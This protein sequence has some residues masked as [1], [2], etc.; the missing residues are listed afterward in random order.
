MSSPVIEEGLPSRNRDQRTCS[1]GA[2]VTSEFGAL[3]ATYHLAATCEGHFT[4]VAVDGTTSKENS[5][6]PPLMGRAA[7]KHARQ[8]AQFTINI[9]SITGTAI[10]GVSLHAICTPRETRVAHAS[11]SRQNAGVPVNGRCRLHGPNSPVHKISITA[12]RVWKIYPPLGLTF[13]CCDPI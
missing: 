10:G 1:A 6:R 5:G 9:A 13:S 8:Y 3:Y 12:A 11:L 7:H 2:A 4:S